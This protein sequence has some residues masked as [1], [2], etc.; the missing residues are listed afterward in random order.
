MGF[1]LTTQLSAAR[2]R[3]IDVA[4]E[5]LTGLVAHAKHAH[6]G[7]LQAIDASGDVSIAQLA[8]LDASAATFLREKAHRK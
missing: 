1:D 8:D 7:M 5:L 3:A 6:A 2:A 4:G